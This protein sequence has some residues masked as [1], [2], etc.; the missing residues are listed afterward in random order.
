M[1]AVGGGGVRGGGG[2]G[3]GRG[4]TAVKSADHSTSL[5]SVMNV[6]IK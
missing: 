4:E 1:E 2:G 3:G 6:F 5:I